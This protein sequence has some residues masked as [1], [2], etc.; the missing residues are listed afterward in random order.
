MA[1]Y[2]SYFRVPERLTLSS[3]FRD[4]A[5]PPS[6][7]DTL[8]EVSLM[9]DVS[10]MT[11]PPTRDTKSWRENWERSTMILAPYTKIHVTVEF[12]RDTMAQDPI[13]FVETFAMSISRSKFWMSVRLE[14]ILMI[15]NNP[16]YSTSSTLTAEF[17]LGFAPA[18]L[19]VNAVFS[20][21]S[22]ALVIVPLRSI[23]LSFTFHSQRVPVSATT[24]KK[25]VDAKCGTFITE[26]LGLA[27][28]SLRNIILSKLAPNMPLLFC[29]GYAAAIQ[30]R[31]KLLDTII[32]P[33]LLNIL[34]RR[35]SRLPTQENNN[36]DRE[37]ILM[38][39]WTVMTT[40][41]K[42]KHLGSMVLEQFLDITPASNISILTNT[43]L[44]EANSVN[45][46]EYDP[47]L[48]SDAMLSVTSEPRLM[49][50]FSEDMSLWA[51]DGFDDI[52]RHD[53]A[54]QDIEFDQCESMLFDSEGD[55]E[56]GNEDPHSFVC[57]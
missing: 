48:S 6:Q 44:S 25:R 17:N 49:D 19:S 55:K 47:K 31:F 40:S 21:H 8:H 15:P 30:D 11:D 53:E 37:T 22:T 9:A 50:L 54:F 51:F 29:P 43:M 23:S 56:V 39:L 12:E 2:T 4:P 32:V 16:H 5:A 27:D 3:R 45:N 10:W 41:L 36:P 18:S 7:K 1:P 33:S 52:D 34:R 42:R 28:I 46:S 38:N 57:K 26:M 13:D 14:P 20:S 24:P 35:Q